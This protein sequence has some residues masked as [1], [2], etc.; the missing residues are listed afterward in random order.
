MSTI[1]TAGFLSGA[2]N[3]RPFAT[4]KANTHEM[5]TEMASMRFMSIRWKESGRCCGVGYR[6][7]RGVSQENLPRY[8]AFFELTHNL[9][10]RGK[11]LFE[12]LITALINPS[13]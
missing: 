1:S 2:I 7:H 10:K 13:T 11:A 6:P 4:A 9:R 5:K 8:L 3:I 12:S